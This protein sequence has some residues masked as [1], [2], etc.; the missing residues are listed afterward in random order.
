MNSPEYTTCQNK[1]KPHSP[2]WRFALK[3]GNAWTVR[4]NRSGHSRPDLIEIF[5]FLEH[6][7]NNHPAVK[8]VD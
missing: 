2:S 7:L 4:S 8:I 3:R 5:H 1:D 6:P